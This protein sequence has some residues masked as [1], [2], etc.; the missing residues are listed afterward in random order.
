MLLCALLGVFGV[1]YLEGHTHPF[2][3]FP[4]FMARISYIEK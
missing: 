3:R 2:L 4:S 1:V